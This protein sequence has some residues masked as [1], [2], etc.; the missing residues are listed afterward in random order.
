MTRNT[1]NV[2]EEDWVLVLGKEKIKER[3]SPSSSVF[4]AQT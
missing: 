4:T 2:D 1:E 3:I